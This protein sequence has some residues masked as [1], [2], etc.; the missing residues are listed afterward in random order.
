MPSPPGES[1][2]FPAGIGVME[3]DGFP[4]PLQCL[5]SHMVH[6]AVSKIRRAV[7]QKL[8]LLDDETDRTRGLVGASLQLLMNP[9]QVLLQFHFKPKSVWVFR[10]YAGSAATAVQILERTQLG[11]AG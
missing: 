10:F 6:H 4:D 7:F 11:H 5:D 2:A 3:K 1:L 9:Y 8:R